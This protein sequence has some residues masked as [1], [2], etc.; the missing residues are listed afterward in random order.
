MNILLIHKN[1]T[2]ILPASIGYT[3]LNKIKTEARIQD[4]DNV[5]SELIDNN[6]PFL[7]WEE[8]YINDILSFIKEFRNVKSDKPIMIL[9]ITELSVAEIKMLIGFGHI[10]IM[11]KNI[12]MDE[13]QSNINQLE[14]GYNQDWM[15]DKYIQHKLLHH[16]LTPEQN[17]ASYQFKNTEIAILK[18]ASKG[19]SIKQIAEEIDLSPNTIAAY[20]T[21]M[22]KKSGMQNFSQLLSYYNN[23]Y[24]QAK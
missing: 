12:S 20:R 10:I 5:W 9:E 7:F 8:E 17:N 4:Y 22:L 23:Q 11:S 2:S 16:L 6:I 1:L 3:L 18:S 15:I 24:N 21:Q 13:L 19:N 14:N